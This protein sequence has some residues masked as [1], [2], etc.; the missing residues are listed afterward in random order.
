MDAKITMLSVSVFPTRSGQLLTRG[1]NHGER[2]ED[3]IVRAQIEL[4]TVKVER[5]KTAQYSYRQERRDLHCAV[6]TRQW[7]PQHGERS[8]TCHTCLVNTQVLIV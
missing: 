7:H 8:E 4:Q 3:E 1:H 5:F 6:I 2:D